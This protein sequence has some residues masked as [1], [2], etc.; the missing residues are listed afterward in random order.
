M[1]LDDLYGEKSKGKGKEID[2]SNDKTDET[3]VYIVTQEGDGDSFIY[4]Y[5]SRK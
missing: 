3:V 2:Y 5:Y 4:L 1:S